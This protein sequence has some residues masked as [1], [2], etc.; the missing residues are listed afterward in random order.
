MTPTLQ[1]IR[2]RSQTIARLLKT[3]LARRFLPLA[4]VLVLSLI[5][6]ASEKP[7]MAKVIQ[8]ISDDISAESR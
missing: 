2:K 8:S 4:I 1:S 7:T 6:Y 5:Y 3:E